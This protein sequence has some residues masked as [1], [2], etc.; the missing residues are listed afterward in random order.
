MIFTTISFLTTHGYISEYWQFEVNNIEIHTS[1]IYLV[2][3]AI[4][5]G[6]V[7]TTAGGVKLLRIYALSRLAS[8]ELGRLIDPES[9]APS[10][11]AGRQ[12]RKR[13]GLNAFVFLMLFMAGIS[14]TA[15]LFTASGLGFEE[16]LMSAIA[17]TTNC[18]PII[19]ILPQHHVPLAESSNIILLIFGLAMVFGRVEVFV[20]IAI[21]NPS[22]WRDR[23][24]KL[25]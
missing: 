11:I 12:L 10:G 20:L 14:T 1:S 5:G 13:G 21:I 25:Q 9:I 7:A 4:L 17:A 16:S 19:N 18:G 24:F 22:F 2:G 8:R 3:L 6:G 15:L 23:V